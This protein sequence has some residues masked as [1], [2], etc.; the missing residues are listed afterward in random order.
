MSKDRDTGQGKGSPPKLT[1]ARH[2]LGR[3]LDSGPVRIVI[4]VLLV[5]NAVT[6]GLE[7]SP[8]LSAATGSALAW[9]NR[10]AVTIFV[11]EIGVRLLAR[12]GRFFRGPWNIFDVVVIGV[13]LIPS[14]GAFSALRALRVIRVL[15]L[16]SLYPAMGN[17][18]V[19]LARAVPAIASIA[20]L[21]FVLNYV[22]SVLM[23]HLYADALPS[24]F[25]TVGRSMLTMFQ[26]M[27]LEDWAGGIVEPLMTVDTNSLFIVIPYMMLT[28]FAIL[29]LVVA[30]LVDAVER[31]R[32]ET[33]TEA[34]DEDLDELEDLDRQILRELGSLRAQVEIL[35][36][37]QRN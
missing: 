20:V 37:R 16:V 13:S 11:I 34:L 29:N 18:V 6:L 22:F 14:L 35:S 36:S 2:R 33:A 25:G 15:R 5:G 30:V 24:L 31:L 27:T 3:F 10:I 12:G 21:L 26:L 19:A 17:V 32:E 9:M 23:T 8:T 1:A 28:A 7:T 4:A